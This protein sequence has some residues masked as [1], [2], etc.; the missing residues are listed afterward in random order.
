M[1]KALLNS[2]LFT[3]LFIVYTSALA[4]K[5]PISLGDV[6]KEDVEMTEYA[7]DPDAEAVILCDYGYLSFRFN[8]TDWAWQRELKR[9][10]RIKILNDDGY[11]WAEESI[12]LYDNN[13][14]EENISSIKGYTYN[15]EN[16]KVQKQKLDKKNI[17]KEK[18]SKNYK[19]VKF[20]MPNVKEGSV[21]EFSYTISSNYL[22]ILEPWYFQRSI[23][24]K[25]SEYIVNTPEF[26]TYLKNATG[27]EE[28]HEYTNTSRPKSINITTMER[29]QAQGFN[30][31]APSSVSQQKR[32][33]I[34]YQSHWVAKDMPALK[35]EAFVGNYANYFQSV[36]FQ[37]SQYKGFQ[38]NIQNILG[39]WDDVVDNL[40]TE[41]DNFGPNIKPRNFYKDITESIKSEYE[42]PVERLAAVYDFVSNYM[43]WNENNGF[44]PR[45]NIKKSYEERTGSSADINA[46]LISMLRDLEINADPVII[47]TVNNGFVN[48]VYP[49]IDKY[50]Y[51][52][53][54]VII[55]DKQVLLDATGK[56]IP[57][58]LLPLRCLNQRGYAICKNHGWVDLKPLKGFEKSAFCMLTMDESGNVSGDISY[59]HDGYSGIKIR[60]NIKTNGKD[61]YVENFKGQK[62]EWVIANIDVVIPEEISSPLKETIKVE[63]IDIAESMG[64]MIYINPIATGKINENPFKQDVRKFPI[65]F[66]VPLKNSYILSLTIPEGFIVDEIPQS[67]SMVTP[68]RS[69]NLKYAV[70][71]TGNRIQVMHSWQIKKSFFSAEKHE[72][73]KQ[74]YAMLVSKHNEQIVLK[75]VESN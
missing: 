20:T 59:K 46:L 73:L 37:L 32:D 14:I 56:D 45:Q 63:S 11:K 66:V 4:Q 9:V 42:K 12:S 62:T 21:V 6:P 52:I 72:E 35:D 53:A 40:L 31:T 25:W 58:G 17:F 61:K 19:K 13:S 67:V 5:P 15:L 60:E 41:N 54:R 68:D 23:P 22:S 49:I 65:E 34:D 70:Q 74:F 36:D 43:K 16:G 55:G 57:L 29:A 51:M 48:P 64:N 28:F 26:F 33:Y 47:S 7:L 8:S 39:S 50:N 27:F 2:I 71:Q 24:V 3:L 75:K 69:A 38:G 30:S 1:M 18:T 44:V 10:C